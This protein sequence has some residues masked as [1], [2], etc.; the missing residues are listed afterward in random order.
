MGTSRWPRVDVQAAKGAARGGKN[1][2]ENAKKQVFVSLTLRTKMPCGE[3]IKVR[4]KKVHESQSR[5]QESALR[6]DIGIKARAHLSSCN[7]C[8]SLR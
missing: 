1:V 8:R 5:S 4:G 7:K 2:G 3:E 6:D